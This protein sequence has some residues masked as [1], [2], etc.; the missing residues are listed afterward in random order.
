MKKAIEMCRR[1]GFVTVGIGIMYFTVEGMYNYSTVVED[2]SIDLVKKTA[3]VI[4]KIV[5][6]EFK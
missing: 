6:T 1:D 2:L 3:H 5:K 4:N